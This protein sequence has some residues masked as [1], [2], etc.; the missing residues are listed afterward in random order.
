MRAW[1]TIEII[2]L[3]QRASR[4]VSVYT[5]CKE[6]LGAVMEQTADLAI[7]ILQILAL[8]LQNIDEATSCDVEVYPGAGQ[9]VAIKPVDLPGS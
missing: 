9:E 4:C 3:R 8:H 5:L 7:D 2:H 1:L 6:G